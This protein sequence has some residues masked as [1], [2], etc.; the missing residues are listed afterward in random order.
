MLEVLKDKINLKV[1]QW[2][3]EIAEN[4]DGNTQINIARDFA[5]IFADN[6]L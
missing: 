6:L 1:T 5:D 4:P 2:K 3:K